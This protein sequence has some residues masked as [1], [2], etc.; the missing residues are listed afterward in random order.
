MFKSR[1]E[2]SKI[3]AF[4]R[5]A[6]QA[7]ELLHWDSCRMDWLEGRGGHLFLVSIL[8]AAT[9]RASA[10]FTRRGSTTENMRLLWQY[11]STLGRPVRIMTNNSSLFQVNQGREAREKESL[12]QIG[13]ALRDLEIERV[14]Y[15]HARMS[16][17]LR[18]FFRIARQKLICDLRIAN[19]HTC[20]EANACLQSVFVPYWN[21]RFRM[22]PV[23]PRDAHR[24]LKK[25]HDLVSI[26]SLQEE[27]ILGRGGIFRWRGRWLQ[28]AEECL[29]GNCARVLRIQQRMDGSAAYTLEGQCVQV[30]PHNDAIQQPVVRPKTHRRTHPRRSQW[31][32]DFKLGGGPPTWAILKREA[33]H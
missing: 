12:T 21:Q 17:S 25:R 27:R 33:A 32:K 20:E 5:E 24:P 28:V 11:L 22:A 1:N 14:P 31:M 13:R 4:E 29:D 30:H 19:A 23:D 8:D 6:A 2:E 18:R 16:H 7:G 10:C 15:N 26:L 9:Q 3:S